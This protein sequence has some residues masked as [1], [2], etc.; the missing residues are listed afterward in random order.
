MQITSKGNIHLI[1]LYLL[2]K[3]KEDMVPRSCLIR[4][5]ALH[6]GSRIHPAVSFSR[7][8]FAS[9]Q[10]HQTSWVQA[11]SNAEKVVGF[12]TS[13]LSLRSVANDEISNIAVYLKKL[14]GTGHPL[15]ATAKNLVYSKDKTHQTRGLL[16]LLMS[17]AAKKESGQDI[18]P[19]Q[20]T[21]AEITE[22]VYTA[23]VIHGGVI[24]LNTPNANLEMGNKMAVLCGD[25]FLAHSCV[26]LATIQNLKIVELIAQAI[27][28]YSTSEFIDVVANE[29][30]SALDR[31]NQQTKLRY[32]SLISHACQ[33]TLILGNN[34]ELA[35]AGKSF[36]MEIALAWQANIE[37]Q[38]YQS[39]ENRA[40]HVLSKLFPET[41]FVE[42]VSN[43]QA[44]RDKH[45][46][47]TLKILTAF[48][49]ND[50]TI[51]LGN[52][53]RALKY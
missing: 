32:G 48:P 47:A 15:I 37:I 23:H 39:S 52:I 12:P 10:V 51:A 18:L 38:T 44:V 4:W 9:T 34:A 30:D 41:S 7:S 42:V 35:E 6:L 33:A 36:G 13:L 49:Q 5:K 16:V 31:W 26:Q 20:R 27:T 17:K 40:D 50:A 21:L 14:I 19:Q 22:L 53:V 8:L 3:K 46:D 25:F 43:F 28:D 1:E 2:L 45:V 11:V 24:N 29:N